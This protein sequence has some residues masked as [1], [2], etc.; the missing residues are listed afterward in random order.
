MV[1]YTTDNNQSAFT[2][3]SLHWAEMEDE[4]EG[5]GGERL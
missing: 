5:F 3:E 1:G 2:P 4:R